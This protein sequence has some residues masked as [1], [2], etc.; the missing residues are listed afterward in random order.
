[1]R[2][3]CVAVHALNSFV[4]EGAARAFDQN[5]I[6]HGIWKRAAELNAELWIERVDTKLN[7]ADNPSRESYALL[8][9]LRAR[10]R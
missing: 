1:M 5:S 10:A 9:R 4:R 8:Q 6:I 3:L 7:V 2:P